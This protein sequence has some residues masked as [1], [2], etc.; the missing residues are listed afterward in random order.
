MSSLLFAEYETLAESLL[1]A[2]LKRWGITYAGLVE[3]LAAIGIAE[4]ERDVTNKISGDGCTAALF[5]Q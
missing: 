5:L 2:E 3:K 1:E 4:D